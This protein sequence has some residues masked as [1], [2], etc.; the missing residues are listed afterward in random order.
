M[1][2]RGRGF[3]LPRI[4]MLVFMLLVL[5]PLA[6]ASFEFNNSDF[7]TEYSP[8]E[9]IIG[10]INI[11]FD[12]EYFDAEIKAGDDFSGKIGLI[13]LLEE[14]FADYTC[15]PDDCEESYTATGGARSK[16]FSLG[17]NQE[18][19]LGFKLTGDD[20]VVTDL[21]FDASA[22]NEP[23]C[24]NPLQIDIL[25]DD[26]VEWKSDKVTSD[27]V[28][29]YD[30]GKGCFKGAGEEVV[31]GEKPYCEKIGLVSSEKFSLGA[32]VKNS[33]ETG[34]LNMSLYDLDGSSCG[35]CE[36]TGISSEGSEVSCIVEYENER[37]QEYYVCINAEKGT[38]YKTKME[39][40]AEN[41]GFYW[42]GSEIPENFSADYHIFAKG[43]K[44]GNIGSFS[45]NEIEYE[46]YESLLED[47][48]NYIEN[49]YNQKCDPC[50]IPLKFNSY[51]QDLSLGISNIS[52]IYSTKT[53]ARK[54][55][56]NIYDVSAEKAKISSDFQILDL[57]YSNIKVPKEHGDYDLMLYLG[58]EEILDD[59][60][61][62]E[63]TRSSVIN[64]IFPKIVSAGIPTKFT[65]EVTS[66]AGRNIT[67]YTWN[68]GDE[69]V[70]NTTVNYVT[71]T[72]LSTRSY[73]LNVEVEDNLGGVSS[74]EFTIIAGNPKKIVNSTIKEYKKRLSNLTS[75]LNLL[76]IWEKEQVEKIIDTE[77]L[78][79]E[80][81]ILERQYNSA[82]DE[83]GYIDVMAGLVD[84]DVPISIKVSGE[85]KTSFFVDFEMIEPSYFEE[86]DAGKYEDYEEEQYKKAIGKWVE[87]NLDLELG[88]KYISGYYDDRI[89]VL[90]SVFNLKV[91]SGEQLDELYVVVESPGTVFKGDC[92]TEDFADATGA[93]LKNVLSEDVGFAILEEMPLDALVLY[94]S[95]EFSMLDVEKIEPC[96]F[97][98]ECEPDEEENWRNCRA[99]CKPWGIVLILLVAIIFAALIAYILLQFW[100][101]KKYESHLFKNKNDLYNITNFIK[102]AKS[103]GMSDKEIK[104]KLKKAGWSGEQISYAFKKLGGKA[105]MPFD[106]LKLFKKVEREKLSKSSEATPGRHA[107]NPVSGGF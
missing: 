12:N 74:K 87:G 22:N 65:L 88:F 38:N 43:A 59:E 29:T 76:S 100:Y 36:L 62:I 10:W 107:F 5:F 9:N 79:S 97:D 83:E 105:I 99:D 68:F 80:L 85:G 55:E 7:E 19:I 45:F 63:V 39:T 24:I 95:P 64:N 104:E 61:E 50:I 90:I 54:E 84:L 66:I 89:E 21:S 58:G 73:S 11:S 1:K 60:V 69:D 86:L 4:F 91:V 25:N 102:N 78:I 14:N 47:I 18:K 17:F 53:T 20:V 57:D 56:T 81:E 31:I 93:K 92:Y 16:S 106:F 52:L 2:K 72:Y 23:F 6:L 30:G 44:F 75:Q 28:C 71:H 3:A 101:K 34:Q 13:D 49:K 26:L 103:Q 33:S 70:E 27:L 15:I 37:A 8:E 46:D 67:S 35:E 82:S 41:C 96:D 77:M 42:Q 51:S 32:W 98:G 94:L 40:S 48:N